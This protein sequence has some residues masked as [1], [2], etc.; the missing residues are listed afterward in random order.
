MDMAGFGL[1]CTAGT[2]TAGAIQVAGTWT[3]DAEGNFTDGT[4]TTGTQEVELPAD[5]LEVS[6]TVTTCERVG[7]PVQSSLGYTTFVCVDNAE[8]GG[9][10]CS[11]A[12]EQ[13]GGL[14][15][16]SLRPLDEGSY[17]TE[18][19]MLTVTDGRDETQFEH[20]VMDN[21]MVLTLATPGKNGTVVGPIVM[22]KP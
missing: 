17:S 21:A 8:T 5:C 15:V 16:L 3:A 12:F 20:C 11:G 6:G 19:T 1:G 7:G 9:C 10:T 2:V 14:A 13:E 22:Q 4:T 18:D